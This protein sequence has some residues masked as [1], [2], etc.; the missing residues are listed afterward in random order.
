MFALLSDVLL[1]SRLQQHEMVLCHG[2]V[3]VGYLLEQVWRAC[4]CQPGS[5]VSMCNDAALRAFCHKEDR[6]RSL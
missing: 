5:T 2:F 3:V 6:C 1:S 4:T